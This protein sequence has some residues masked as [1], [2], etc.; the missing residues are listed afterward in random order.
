MYCQMIRGVY[1]RCNGEMACYCGPGEA[2]NLGNLQPNGQNYCFIK[3]YYFNSK[4]KYIRDSIA[5]HILPFP[6]SCLKCV[7]LKPNLQS[8]IEKLNNEIEWMHIETTSQCNLDCKFCIPQAERRSFREPPYY[9][10]IELFKKIVD[11]IHVN[12]FRVEKMYFSGRGEPCLHPH[13]WDMV[14]YAKKVLNTN[15]LVNTNGNIKFSEQIVNSGLD[16]IKIAIDGIQQEAYEKYRINGKLSKILELT[17]KISDY[18]SKT[19]KNNPKI[20]WQYILFSHN[21]SIED[22][23]EVQKKAI[24][25]GVDE[26]LIKTTYTMDIY[27]TLDIKTIPRIHPNV[28]F[29]DIKEMFTTNLEDINQIYEKLLELKKENRIKDTIVKA[30][31]ISHNIIMGFLLGLSSK[32]DYNLLGYDDTSLIN[33]IKEGKSSKDNNLKSKIELLLS[34]FTIL[35]QTY[36]QVSQQKAANYYDLI[37][38]KSS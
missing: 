30:I 2:I 38:D 26:I 11:D 23:I 34:C 37:I 14:E 9:L 5:N 24:E 12:D 8:G 36:H 21:D 17:K 10:P 33:L 31:D 28:N 18:R 19:G 3:N 1:L 20:I 27:S 35:S 4:H 13:I 16:K 22:L 6:S 29:L 25:L 32:K 7:Y 15:F